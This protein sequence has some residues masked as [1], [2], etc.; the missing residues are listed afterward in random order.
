M[1][2]KT[3][4]V[5][6]EDLPLLEEAQ[7]LTGGNLSAAV[8]RALRGYVDGAR[9]HQAGFGELTVQVG[10]PGAKRLKRFRGYEVA[11]WQ[12]PH[13]DGRQVEMFI[14]YATKGGR[15]AV[16]CRKG[17]NRPWW[18]D[19]V[20]WGLDWS[21]PR[22]DH[23]PPA[24]HHGPEPRLQPLHQRIQHRIHQHWDFGGHGIQE[25]LEVYD[26]LEQLQEHVPP[27]LF[28]LVTEAGQE[29]RL[30]DLDI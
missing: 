22:T 1:P 19:P 28:Q 16:H 13:A 24:P 17:P 11:R 21:D 4:Y 7:A 30:E 20:T 14:I 9:D 6:D 8:A 26:T 3:I 27:E 5:A 15:Y 2:N 29:P 12:L 25:T 23:R 10:P 18:A